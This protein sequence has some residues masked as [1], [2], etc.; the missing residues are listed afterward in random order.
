MLSSFGL[1]FLA[2]LRISLERLRQILVVCDQVVPEQQDIIQSGL[3]LEQYKGY[4]QRSLNPAIEISYH[5]KK[6][7]YAI[8]GKIGSG[9]T[10]LLHAILGQ[11]P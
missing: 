5:F 9:K 10:T 4:W 8:V 6:G 1:D 2:N 11:L 3:L 7:I